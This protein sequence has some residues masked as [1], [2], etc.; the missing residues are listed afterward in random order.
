MKELVQVVHSR[1]WALN[2]PFF[3]CLATFKM[4]SIYSTHDH[5]A[6]NHFLHLYLGLALPILTIK[7]E[8]ENLKLEL[9]SAFRSQSGSPHHGFSHGGQAMRSASQTC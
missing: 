3:F 8:I 2:Y 5:C 6:G 7:R 1:L 9:C 4:A